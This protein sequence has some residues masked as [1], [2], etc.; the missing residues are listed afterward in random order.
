MNGMQQNK[1]RSLLLKYLDNRCTAQELQ[2]VGHYFANVEYPDAFDE[3][4]E[5][6]WKKFKQ[7]TGDDDQLAAELFR[8]FNERVKANN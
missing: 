3:L 5:Q 7:D 8:K 4:L 2:Q 1:L 6:G